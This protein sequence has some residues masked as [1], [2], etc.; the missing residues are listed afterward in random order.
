MKLIIAALLFSSA[1]YA[2]CYEVNN[3]NSKIKWEAFKTAKKVGVK[4]QFTKFEIKTQKKQGE[5]N[6]LIKGARFS[7]DVNSVA[8]KDSSRDLKIEKFFFKDMK[9]SGVVNKVDSNYLYV[10]LTMA[11]K[12]IRVPMMYDIEDAELEAEATI[13]VLDFGLLKNLSALNKAC[14]ALHEGKTWNVVEIEVE[15]KFKQCK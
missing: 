11:G 5:I 2:N 6:E 4:G 14:L 12:T 13:D 3:A 9:I 8:T 10:D 1:I 15:S 7:I